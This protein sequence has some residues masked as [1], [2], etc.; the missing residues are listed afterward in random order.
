MDTQRDHL[1]DGNSHDF[2]SSLFYVCRPGFPDY[3][4]CDTFGCVHSLG[5]VPIHL[6]PCAFF[7][8]CFCH[9]K[10]IDV[11]ADYSFD[12]VWYGFK[13]VDVGSDIPTYKCTNY[14]SVT[15]SQ[16]TSDMCV[17]VAHEIEQGKVSYVTDQPQR[18]HAI[19][20]VAK[21]DGSLRPITDCCR[22]IGSS[23]NNYMDTTAKAFHYKT[24][25]YVAE[26][27][28]PGDYLSVSDIS[29][30]YKTVYV[31]PPPPPPT[32]LSGV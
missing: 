23:I 2:P 14:N 10:G 7:R 3:R 5:N 22:P 1:I 8:E 32:Y 12:G 15:D 6:S 27:I 26:T 30:A 24:L 29:S 9:Y 18:V 28:L 19:G 25:D 16:F 20:G 31:F 11:N 13:I 21:K 4:L 17:N